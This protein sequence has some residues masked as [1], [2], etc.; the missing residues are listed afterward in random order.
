[1]SRQDRYAVCRMLFKLFPGDTSKRMRYTTPTNLAR[2][3]SLVKK[4]GLNMTFPDD[5]YYFWFAD[6]EKKAESCNLCAYMMLCQTLT[7]R[8]GPCTV[9]EEIVSSLSKDEKK[10]VRDTCCIEMA[11]KTLQMES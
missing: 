11:A 4:H 10:C 3:L 5:G 9:N 7:P 8:S 2:H 1:M 6:I